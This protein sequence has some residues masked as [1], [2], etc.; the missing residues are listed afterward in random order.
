MATINQLS[1]ANTYQDWLSA[2]ETLVSLNNDFGE[3]ANGTFFA[4]TSLTLDGNLAVTGNM[5]LDVS[6]FDNLTT[7][8]NLVLEETDTG[9]FFSSSN[10]SGSAAA[11]WSIVGDGSVYGF[12]AFPTGNPNLE[13]TA[14]ETYAFDLQGL[15]GSHPFVIRTTNASGTVGDSSTYYNV[16]L[17]HIEPTTDKRGLV[18]SHGG[19]AQGKTGGILYWKVP[20]NTINETY[21]YQCTAHAGAMVGTIHIENTVEA[22]F[23]AA[24]NT[25]SSDAVGLTAALVG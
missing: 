18:I 13:L 15:N 6:G 25:L 23:S 12:D 9:H 21:Y 1:A 2:T 19:D 5:N 8:G 10:T 22:L 20:A 16:G 11:R 4:N 7:N 3:G 17:S 24:N 14:G